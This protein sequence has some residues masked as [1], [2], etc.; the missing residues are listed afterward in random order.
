MAKLRRRL[1][2][3]AA[4]TDA[5][6]GRDEG[7]TMS[8]LSLALVTITVIVAVIIATRPAPRR[9]RRA[10]QTAA[11]DSEQ[12]ADPLPALSTSNELTPAPEIMLDGTHRNQWDRPDLATGIGRDD[13]AAE[14]DLLL[15]PAPGDSIAA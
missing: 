15:W 2:E 1:P 3:P 6:A 14:P 7:S 10:D 11:S 9:T 8:T 12:S 5:N 4:G 13:Q